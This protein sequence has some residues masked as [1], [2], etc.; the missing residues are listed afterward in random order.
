VCL[1]IQLLEALAYMHDSLDEAGAPMQI[2]HRDITPSNLL[3]TEDGRL[4]VIDFGIAKA[5]AGRFATSSGLVKGK[6]G[7]MAVEAI[8]GKTLDA[9][10]DIFSAGVVLW[11]LL[12]GRRLFDGETDVEVI[13]RVRAGA[14]HAPSTIRP[15]CPPALDRIVMRAITR[16]RR[17]RWASA[18]ALCDALEALDVAA[19]TD[20]I[21][22]WTRS[23][24][25]T[26]MPIDLVP[27]PEAET[28]ST[29]LSH[30][31]LIEL[32]PDEV[33]VDGWERL[34]ASN[35]DAELVVDEPVAFAPKDFGPAKR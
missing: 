12:C 18:R 16:Q 32:A 33:I 7:Y 25:S 35:V 4:K 15:D 23:V 2:V 26:A 30:D 13:A 24:A 31:D 5:V 11:E 22:A 3:V 29:V 8:S 17:E 19:A 20:E 34:L 1:A 21:A 28:T 14:N 9:R 27:P 6:L 10:A